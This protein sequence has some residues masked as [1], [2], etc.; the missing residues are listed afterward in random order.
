V[1]NRNITLI[2]FEISEGMVKLVSNDGEY[3]LYVH[4]DQLGTPEKYD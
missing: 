3:N 2:E 4:E 1:W